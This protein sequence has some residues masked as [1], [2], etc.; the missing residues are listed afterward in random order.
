MIL[1]QRNA[2]NALP[3]VVCGLRCLL[4]AGSVRIVRR[5][6]LE[7]ELLELHTATTL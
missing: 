7:V 1:V 2:E 5:E 3:L 6:H 4:A